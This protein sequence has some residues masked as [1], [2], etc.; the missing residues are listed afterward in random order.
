MSEAAEEFTEPYLLVEKCGSERGVP[1]Y[2]I[3]KHIPSVHGH[4]HR[5]VSMLKIS[6]S[7]TG[8]YPKRTVRAALLRFPDNEA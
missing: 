1:I 8:G 7:A 5:S 4:L 3:T 6:R 2:V